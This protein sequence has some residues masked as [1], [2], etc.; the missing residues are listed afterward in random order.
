MN[1]YNKTIEFY[2]NYHELTNEKQRE[3]LEEL[4]RKIAECY[5]QEAEE[6]KMSVKDLMVKE[7][8]VVPSWIE[9]EKEINDNWSYCAEEF[10]EEKAKKILKKK[11]DFKLIFKF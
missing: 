2:V 7:Y 5:K 3:I 10:I 4:K 1:N 9:D 11:F 8:N 6:K